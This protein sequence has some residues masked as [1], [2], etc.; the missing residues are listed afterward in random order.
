MKTSKTRKIYFE[1]ARSVSQLSD[2]P[3]VKVGAVAVYKHHII[4]SG[5]NTRK[6]DPLQKKYNMYRF[7]EETP[8][9]AHAELVCLKPL[10]DHHD[11]DFKHVDLYV[12]RADKQ[13]VP[14]LARPCPSCMQ[15]I[16]DLGIRN[17]YYTNNNGFSH[18]NILE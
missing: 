10:I 15:L 5:C 1:T 12:Y 6:T 17:I 4:S 9:C 18:E 8:H 11:I 7:S 2:F 14:L 13:G 3:R 16:K